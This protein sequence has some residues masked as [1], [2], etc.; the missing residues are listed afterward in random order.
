MASVSM[1]DHLQL[2]TPEALFAEIPKQPGPDETMGVGVEAKRG[3]K[4][5]VLGTEMHPLLKQHTELHD[6]AD[7]NK[8]LQFTLGVVKG[9]KRKCVV[10]GDLIANRRW[11]VSRQQDDERASLWF[12]IHCFLRRY[13]I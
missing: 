13:N 8:R 5:R 4:K 2:V 6:T 3:Q 1:S 7:G 11:R 9:E 12:H 10:C